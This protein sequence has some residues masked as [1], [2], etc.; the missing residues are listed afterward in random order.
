MFN[1]AYKYTS[2]VELQK[3]FPRRYVNIQLALDTVTRRK[4][5]NYRE[6]ISFMYHTTKISFHGTR[7]TS[8][9]IHGNRTR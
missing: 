2:Y 8:R 9:S 7:A 1:R 4:Y 5:R 3:L 6:V